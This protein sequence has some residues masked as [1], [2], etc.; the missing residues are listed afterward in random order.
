MSIFVT[1]D[2]VSTTG[3]FGGDSSVERDGMGRPRII[4]GCDTCDGSGTTPSPKTGRLIKCQ[5]C[6]G[7]GA[8]K[9]RS[10]TRTTTFID[11]LEDKSNIAEWKARKV[12]QG[13]AMDPSLLR[14]V[15][16][17]G[18]SDREG[19]D[20]LNRRAEVAAD[21]A[22]AN[23]KSAKGT[24]LHEVSE[25]V[26]SGTPLSSIPNLT[27]ADQADIKAYEV[28]T[29]DLVD[30]VLMEKLMVHDE[31]QVAGTPDRVS[32]LKREMVAPDGTV[33]HPDSLLITDLKTGRVDYGKLKMAMQLSIYSRSRLYFQDGRRREVHGLRTDWGLIMHLPAG[34]ANLTIYWADLNAGWDAVLLAREVRKVRSTKAL[35]PFP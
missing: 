32:H 31:L 5:P 30:I 18:D 24:H 9:K 1:P 13:V 17:Y 33:I 25:L 20:W 7:Q 4:V 2:E 11:V 23:E 34:E 6:A 22:G 21:K 19:R 29:R 10:Y 27:L 12:L 16:D 35:V 8:A 15:L 28:G 26:D 3:K 14:D